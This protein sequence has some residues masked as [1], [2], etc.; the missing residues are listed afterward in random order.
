MAAVTQYKGSEEQALDRVP[1]FVG[2][3]SVTFLR[4][5]DTEKKEDTQRQTAT[6]LGQIGDDGPV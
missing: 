1:I 2:T 6:I 4:I 3:Q 5:A